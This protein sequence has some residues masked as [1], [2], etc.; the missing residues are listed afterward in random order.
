[1]N[2]DIEQ[3]RE[4]SEDIEQIRRKIEE[5]ID[6]RIREKMID[7]TRKRYEI[8]TYD[9]LFQCILRGQFEPS[10]E[11][12]QMSVD[13]DLKTMITKTPFGDLE[14]SLEGGKDN[15]KEI[16][17]KFKKTLLPAEEELLDYSIKNTLNART[18]SHQ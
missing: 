9:D 12:I 7:E 1:M 10:R 14:Q 13:P 3:K 2:A 11:E 6:K 8:Y 16:V 5:D 18:L 15:E 17:G 4:I